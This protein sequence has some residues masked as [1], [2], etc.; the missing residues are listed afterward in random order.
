MSMTELASRMST[1]GISHHRR[2]AQRKL[3]SSVAMSSRARTLAIIVPPGPRGPAGAATKNPQLQAK[4]RSAEVRCSPGLIFG[5]ELT[6]STPFSLNQRS[7]SPT[8]KVFVWGWQY[9]S[10]NQMRFFSSPNGIRHV[11]EHAVR[12]DVV[13]ALLPEGR[14]E[15]VHLDEPGRAELEPFLERLP[16]AERIVPEVDADDPALHH[17]EKVDPRRPGQLP[18]QELHVDAAPGLLGQVEWR[19]DLLIARER[20]RFV[21]LTDSMGYLVDTLR[22]HGLRPQFTT[23]VLAPTTAEFPSGAGRARP[24]VDPPRP[25]GCLSWDQRDSIGWHSWPVR[26]ARLASGRIVNERGEA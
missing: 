7:T 21:E 6:Y 9:W 3:R 18:I 20:T 22:A 5:N 24:P 25:G 1:I 13:E 15:K 16:L 8:L 14:P 26:R 4:R 23:L 2:T 17:R 11:V 19:L 12:E 10:M